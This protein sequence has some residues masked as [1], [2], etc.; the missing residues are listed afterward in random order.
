MRKI[1]NIRNKDIYGFRILD[2][3]GGWYERWLDD[4]GTRS[5]V[6]SDEL[7]RIIIV[8]NVYTLVDALRYIQTAANDYDW[9]LEVYNYN[10]WRSKGTLLSNFFK[11]F[12]IKKR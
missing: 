4:G 6:V 7:E 12:L 5:L 11:R 3:M 10:D 8:Q 9:T 2:N 1:I